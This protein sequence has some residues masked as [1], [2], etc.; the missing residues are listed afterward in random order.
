MKKL[1]L[2][3]DFAIDNRVFRSRLMYIKNEH[4]DKSNEKV[5]YSLIQY[6]YAQDN[7]K[8]NEKIVKYIRNWLNQNTMLD[9]D[10]ELYFSNPKIVKDITRMVDFM[11][12]VIKKNTT[13]N[14]HIKSVN[15]VLKKNQTHADK[16]GCSEYSYKNI[17]ENKLKSPY[18]KRILESL[19]DQL[20]TDKEKEYA[21]SLFDYLGE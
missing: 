19:L 15:R 10:D 21:K 9:P 14:S 13:D 4:G 20:E 12:D 18:S 3:E 17:I 7:I 8:D 16:V 5:I 6:F 2:E 11:V 1:S